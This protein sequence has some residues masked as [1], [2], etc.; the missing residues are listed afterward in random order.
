M[1][2]RLHILHT[3][4][5]AP[6]GGLEQ[7]VKLLAATQAR[8]GHGVSVIG[9]LDSGQEDHPVLAGLREEGVEARALPVP[10]RRYRLERSSIAAFC[11]EARPDILHTHG[12]RAD[13]L[14]GAVARSGGIPHVAT[15]HGFTGGDWKN[16]LYEWL[17]RRSL[18]RAD[19][20][21]AVS[22]PLLTEL[23]ESGLHPERAHSIPNAWA[24]PA[25]RLGRREAREALEIDGDAAAVG[26]VGRLSHEKGA[27][28][29]VESLTRMREPVVGHVIGSGPLEGR[30]RARVR[31]LGIEERVRFHGMV[32][33]AG[34][35]LPAL[36][37]FVL[38]SRTE[39][40]PIA[41]F[42]AMAAGVPIVAAGVGGVPNV[43]SEAEALLVPTEAPDALARAVDDVLADPE[44]ADLRAERA[45]DRLRSRFDPES[46]AARY[47]R[48]YRAVVPAAPAR[49]KGRR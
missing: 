27:D 31:D 25:P 4:A 15:V 22:D 8:A 21:V 9:V 49:T 13:I 46:W 26:F 39:G 37:V 20:V 36:D 3:F 18:R 14:H 42:E 47:D 45:R 28:V 40:T 30:L 33:E 6:F 29:F 12:Y 48:V 11:R 5:P 35:L 2:G 23:L 44:S 38:S 24:S 10:P 1:S 32:A 41:L 34:R 19:A 7:V 43:V 16:R 17:Q